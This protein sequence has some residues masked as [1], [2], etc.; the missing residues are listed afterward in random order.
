MK[1]TP[2]LSLVAGEGT[3]A[4]D[5]HV[6]TDPAVGAYA[7]SRLAAVLEDAWAAIRAQHPDIDHAVVIIGPGTGTGRPAEHG[8]YGSLRWRHRH[9][10]A[11]FAEVLVAGEG[12]S[13]TAA[14]VLGTLL[15]EAA[16]AL[17][18]ARQV[19]DTSRQGRWHNKH[20]A[21][22]AT[23]LGLAVE[24][25]DKIGFR[26][27]ITDLTTGRY[28]STIAAL[29]GAITLF[30][31]PIEAKPKKK[32]D[33]SNN[34]IPLECLCPRK[35]KVAPTIAEAG[36][37]RCDVCGHAFMPDGQPDPTLTP[38]PTGA[39]HDGMPTFPWGTVPNG[40]ATLRQ[41]AASG[42][43]PGGQPIAARLTWRHGRRFANLY[44]LDAAKTKRQATP[45]QLDALARANAARAA[46]RGDR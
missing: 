33:N 1:A 30:R 41:L 20:F 31:H 7:I 10:D 9:S 27:T 11:E 6:S 37:I 38:D 16:H 40:L 44:R 28:Q 32:R 39:A 23:E 21:Q 29:D 12:L 46:K 15:H 18:D 17:A 43:R 13:R 24:P 2:A 14:E 5:T 36:L 4:V 3:T 19:K 34:P 22:L 45:A 35:I 25:D 26:T 8:H 42:L